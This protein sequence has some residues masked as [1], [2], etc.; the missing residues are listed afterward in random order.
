MSFAEAALKFRGCAEYAQWP[1]EKT[2]ALIAFVQTMETAP[3]IGKLTPLL[4]GDSA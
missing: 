2:E 1:K 3:D 4:S